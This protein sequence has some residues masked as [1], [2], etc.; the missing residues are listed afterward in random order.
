M[1]WRLSIVNVS[2]SFYAAVRYQDN[3]FRRRFETSPIFFLW[4]LCN[5]FL[6]YKTHTNLVQLSKHNYTRNNKLIDLQWIKIII[7]Y[8]ENQNWS[9][10]EFSAPCLTVPNY[11]ERMA[12]YWRRLSRNVVKK[13]NV[14]FYFNG[15]PFV[16]VRHELSFDSRVKK[17]WCLN[18]VTSRSTL[19]K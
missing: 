10:I 16:V 5:L 8:V 4:I 1:R 7:A 6:Q 2:R 12:D 14:T 13:T 11:L 9:A 18:I 19:Y 15:F 3:V 17:T